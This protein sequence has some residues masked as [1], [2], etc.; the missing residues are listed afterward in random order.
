VLERDPQHDHVVAVGLVVSCQDME[1][2]SSNSRAALGDVSAHVG[3]LLIAEPSTSTDVVPD[4]LR[5]EGTLQTAFKEGH[6]TFSCCLQWEMP[7]ST[8]CLMSSLVCG[9]RT[10]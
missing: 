2:S 3:C 5:L 6:H 9:T 10:S 1:D 8:P 4:G 7:G